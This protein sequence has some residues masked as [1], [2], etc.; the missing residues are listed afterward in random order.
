MVDPVALFIK[1]SK[2][3]DYS[4][5]VKEFERL[6]E[7]DPQNTGFLFQ[8]ANVHSVL[9]KNPKKA[10]ELHNQIL[11]LDPKFTSARH[12][13]AVCLIDLK[14]YKDAIKE[15]NVVLKSGYNDNI[16]KQ[17][18]FCFEKLK[19]YKRSVSDLKKCVSL[20]ESYKTTF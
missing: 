1:L 20:L 10:L 17:R 8:L 14:Q 4:K 3:N 16:Y 12:N 5:A 9:G 11:K 2:K 15:F 13:K 19:D 18:A 7:K 6:L